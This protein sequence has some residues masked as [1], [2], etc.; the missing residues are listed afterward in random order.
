LTEN[1]QPEPKRFRP[2]FSY[3]GAV[4]VLGAGIWLL[5]GTRVN[6]AVFGG[7]TT[8]RWSLSP[9][10]L[11]AVAIGAAV[12]V[13]AGTRNIAGLGITAGVSILLGAMFVF[14][15]GLVLAGAGLVLL[16]AIGLDI[17]IGRRGGVETRQAQ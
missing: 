13:L 16:V 12:F 4:S 11:L 7:S 8:S 1:T 15:G 17:V 3:V 5:L 2:R 6:T 14:S 10:G 9:I